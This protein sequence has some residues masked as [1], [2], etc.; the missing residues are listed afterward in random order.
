V[1][2]AETIEREYKEQLATFER[3]HA[4]QNEGKPSLR[5]DAPF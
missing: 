4:S 3:E 1:R 2:S 5:D